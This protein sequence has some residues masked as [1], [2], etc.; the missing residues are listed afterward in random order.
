MSLDGP[1][2][3]G[4]HFALT[5]PSGIGHD[6]QVTSERHRLIANAPGRRPRTILEIDDGYDLEVTIVDD[7]WV[8]RFPRRA[9]ADEALELEIERLPVLAPALRW[10]CPGSSSFR[11]AQP[12]SATA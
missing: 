4:Q 7:D 8:F 6:E 10:T 2:E 9:A 12:S 3:P 11:A 1:G 5:P